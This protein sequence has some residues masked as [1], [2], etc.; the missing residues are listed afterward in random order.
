MESDVKEIDSVVFGVLSPEDILKMSVVKINTTKLSGTGSV[1]DDR[2][3]GNLESGKLCPTCGENAKECVGHFGHIELNVWIIHPLY[4]KVVVSFLKC[5]CIK[6]YN[7]LVL[8]EQIEL[9]GLVKTKGEKRFRKIIDILEKID[10]C[11]H[12]SNPQPKFTHSISDNTISM[13]Y[14]QK[15]G[16][17]VVI[18]LAVEEIKK[19]LD[20]V[21][22]ENVELLGFNPSRI[23]PKNLIL[24]LI[25]VLPPSSRPF[26][27]ADGN[28]CDD[29]LTNQY[30]EIIKANN[31]LEDLDPNDT[32]YQK[33][34]QAIKFR[35]LTLYNNSQGRSKHTTSGRPIKG[36]KERLTGKDGLIRNNLMGKRC[37]QTGRTVIGP[38]PTLRMGQL[39]LPPEMASN[40]TFPESITP[41]NIEK[42]SELVNNGKANFVIR[43]KEGKK[44]RINLHY[45]LYS[46]GTE[47]LYGD[48]I[49]RNEKEI[50]ISQKLCRNFELKSGDIIKRNGNILENITY[51]KK[52]KFILQIGDIVERHLR[53]GDTVLLNRQPTLHSG[54]MMAKEIII[55]PGKTIRMNLSCTKSFNADFDK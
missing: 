32:K 47:L 48:V 52:K 37:E 3:G 18:P 12:C 33:F 44:T 41:F 24:S 16:Q 35:L 10:I 4:Y 46:K 22:N 31:H 29:D 54:S 19:I 15:I 11:C 28:I 5:F 49:L 50:K 51:P 30:T 21:S 20:N 27:M 8:K 14:N 1:Y 34:L 26:V 2:L 13:V 38:D 9:Y 17:N 39:A 23:H 53:N 45:A 6:C 55:R 43:E 25:P 7:L 40:L 42:M 36:I